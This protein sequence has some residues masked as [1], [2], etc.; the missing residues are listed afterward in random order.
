[1]PVLIY[2]PA[3]TIFLLSHGVDCTVLK[4][5]EVTA[6]IDGDSQVQTADLVKAKESDSSLKEMIAFLPP[7]ALTGQAARAI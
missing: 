1:L 5:T 7:R 2:L 4:S 6:Y 3:A